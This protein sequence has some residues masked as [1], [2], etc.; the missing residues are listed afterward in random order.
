[1]KRMKWEAIIMVPEEKQEALKQVKTYSVE[2][3]RAKWTACEFQEIYCE[4]IDPQMDSVC[5][6]LTAISLEILDFAG[7]LVKFDT[8]PSLITM[9][10][11]YGV[12]RLMYEHSIQFE[13]LIYTALN[14]GDHYYSLWAEKQNGRGR[15]VLDRASLAQAL[16][17]WYY[18]VFEPTSIRFTKFGTEHSNNFKS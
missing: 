14:A 13:R 6:N 1:M 11:P 10:V 2:L 12:R 9:H 16:W 4:W 18:S 5:P 15:S 7:C 17:R 8:Y 3:A